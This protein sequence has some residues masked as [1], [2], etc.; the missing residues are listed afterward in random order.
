MIF[1]LY[2]NHLRRY[3]LELAYNQL[4]QLQ[5]HKSK[6]NLSLNGNKIVLLRASGVIFIK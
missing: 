2:Q 1:Y 4:F 6:L 3:K 5:I